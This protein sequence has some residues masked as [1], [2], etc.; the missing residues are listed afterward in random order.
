MST[1]K[2]TRNFD[3]GGNR[4]ASDILAGVKGIEYCTALAVAI[5]AKAIIANTSQAKALVK[6]CLK[7]AGQ[8]ANAKGSPHAAELSLLHKP[9]AQLQRDVLE[10]HSA[11]LI[12]LKPKRG[13]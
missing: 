4:T 8:I 3:G 6:R 10:A 12:D 1:R 2:R 13:K 7:L 11:G 5:K 9:A